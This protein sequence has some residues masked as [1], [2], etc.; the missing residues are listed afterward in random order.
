[1]EGCVYSLG[2]RDVWLWPSPKGQMD[3]GCKALVHPVG[4]PLKPMWDTGIRLPSAVCKGHMQ[5]QLAKLSKFQS[6][7][8]IRLLPKSGF[9]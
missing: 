1:M 5:H 2:R 9:L 3:L 8:R 4:M 7:S 6:C